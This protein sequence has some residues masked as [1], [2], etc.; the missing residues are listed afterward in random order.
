MAA[1]ERLVE[2]SHGKFRLGISGRSGSQS[3]EKWFPEQF[4]LIM[5]RQEPKRSPVLEQLN[6]FIHDQSEYHRITEQFGW[7]RP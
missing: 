4:S 5:E 1:D 3:R 6:Y 2:C 7:K